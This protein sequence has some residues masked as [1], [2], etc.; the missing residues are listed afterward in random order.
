MPYKLKLRNS[1]NQNIS[2]KILKRKQGSEQEGPEVK[3]LRKHS[4]ADNSELVISGITNITPMKR[5][6]D[7]S[8]QD[9]S[10]SNLDCKLS[11]SPIYYTIKRPRYTDSDRPQDSV[12]TW[13]T[14]LVTSTPRTTPNTKKLFFIDHDKS[15]QN[16]IDDK[17]ILLNSQNQEQHKGQTTKENLGKK[18]DV[19]GDGNCLFWSIFFGYLLPVKNDIKEF[20]TRCSKILPRHNIEEVKQYCNYLKLESLNT[21]NR[22]ETINSNETIGALIQ[23][24]RKRAY[25]EV[26]V[27]PNI[28]GTP[29]KKDKMHNEW[30]QIMQ[31]AQ[32]NNDNV[33]SDEFWGEE[34]GLNALAHLLDI[35]INVE[36][37]GQKYPSQ[38]N[39]YNK[40]TGKQTPLKV[41]SNIT[42]TL[43][44]ENNHYNFYYNDLQH[45]IPFNINNDSGIGDSFNLSAEVDDLTIVEEIK[46]TKGLKHLSICNKDNIAKSIKYAD[47]DRVIPDHNVNDHIKNTS[48]PRKRK[49]LLEQ[50]NIPQKK[51][52]NIQENVIQIN[53]KEND[54]T[55]TK[56]STRHFKKSKQSNQDIDYNKVPVIKYK[57]SADLNNI[58]SQEVNKNSTNSNSNTEEYQKRLTEELNII[59]QFDYAENF[60]IAANIV[61]ICQYFD[62]R[63]QLIGSANSS[64]VAKAL[65]IHTINPIEH[66][67]LFEVFLSDDRQPDFDFYIDSE[68]RH[69]ICNYLITHAYQGR[70]GWMMKKNNSLH[71]SAIGIKP[72]NSNLAIKNGNFTDYNKCTDIKGFIKFDL[73]SS[74]ELYKFNQVCKQQTDVTKRDSLNDAKT[75]QLIANGDVQNL[76]QIS[77]MGKVCKELHPT[78]FNDLV[79]LLAVNRSIPQIRNTNI[80]ILAG[81]QLSSLIDPLSVF[82]STKGVILFKEQIM[83]AANR[84]FGVNVKNTYQFLKDLKDKKIGKDEKKQYIKKANIFTDQA[85]Q[86]FTELQKASSSVFSKAHAISCAKIIYNSAYVKAHYP[87]LFKQVYNPPDNL[88][89]RK[90]PS[91][92]SLITLDD[93][94]DNTLDNS[95]CDQNND[96]AAN[97]SIRKSCISLGVLY[98]LELLMLILNRVSH[99]HDFL[100]ATEEVSTGKFDDITI[101]YQSQNKG[102]YIQAKYIDVE[103]AYN[104]IGSTKLFPK[105]KR[106]HTAMFSIQRYFEFFVKEI[107]NGKLSDAEYLIIYTN[108]NLDTK[109]DILKSFFL[110]HYNIKVD[111]KNIDG[112]EYKILRD[113]LYIKNASNINKKQGFY[114][115]SQESKGKILK[116]LKCPDHDK[117]LKDSFLDKLILAVNQPNVR[118]LIDVIESEMVQNNE[119]SKDSYNILQ[120]NIFSWAA[121]SKGYYITEKNVKEFFKENKLPQ[122][123]DLTEQ[124]SKHYWCNALIATTQYRFTLCTFLL[125]R[126]FIVHPSDELR[127]EIKEN[128]PHR[129]NDIYLHDASKTTYIHI[130]STIEPVSWDEVIASITKYFN[131][132]I[133]T[134]QNNVKDKDIVYYINIKEIEE[135]NLHVIDIENSE[136]QTLKNYLYINNKSEESGFYQLSQEARQEI[137]EQ[138]KNKTDFIKL[139]KIYKQLFNKLVLAVNQPNSIELSSIIKLEMKPYYDLN[140]NYTT[141]QK[142]LLSWLV[143]YDRNHDISN[144]NWENFITEKSN[145]IANQSIHSIDNR[146]KNAFV[147]AIVGDTGICNF[148]DLRDFLKTEEGN[149]MFNVFHQNKIEHHVSSI[150]SN[151]GANVKKIFKEFYNILF[152]KDGQKTNL[153]KYFTEDRT[154]L[155]SI[156]SMLCG[157]GAKAP[158]AL[159]ALH[160]MLSTTIPNGKQTYLQFFV[161]KKI[162]PNI[163]SM[164]CGAG[165]KA[166]EALKALHD[167]LS[168]TIPNGKQTYLQFFVKKK[169]MPNISS[170]LCG[171]GDKAPEALKA[172][173]DMLSTTIPNGK[174]TYL[175]FFV[176][177]KIMPNISSMLCGAGDKAPEALKA[178][179]DMLS[180]TIPN[181]EQTYLQFFVEKKIM[182]N[183]SSMLCGAGAKAPEALK[184]LHDML[185]TTIPNGEQTYLQFFVEKKIMPNISSMLHGAGAKAPEA[186]KALHDMLSTTI[187]NGE[188]TYLQFF[189]EKKIMPN[190]SSMLHGAGDKAPEALKALH[191]MLSTTIPNGEQT[192]LQ[193]FVEKKIMPNISSMLC[194]AGDKAPEALK[195]LHDMLSTTIPNGE[196]TYLQF[197]VEKKI[198]PNISSMLHGAGAKAPE[199]LKALHDMLS[200][201]IPNGEQ[202]YLQFFVEKKIMPN[203]SSMLCGAGAKAPEALKALHDMLSTTIPNGEQTYLQFFVEKKIMPNISSMLCG[204]GDKAPE[205]L[206]ALHD[207]LSTTIPNGEQ[208]YLQFFVEKK[209]MPNISSMLNG[210][211]AKAPE[212]LKALHDMLS[213]TIPNGEQTYLQFFV[214]KKI[215]PNISSMLHGAGAKAPEALK[216]LHDMLSTT[217]P[218]GEQTY[219]QFFVEK[220]IMPNISS[221]LCGAG[222]KAPE[223][224]KALHD[225][226][227][228][229]IPNGEQTYLQ[230]FVEKKIMPNISSMLCG[231]GAKAPEA[232]KALHDM[233][234]TTIPNGEQ[235]YLQFFVE[236]KIMPN[237][238]SMLHGAGAKAPEAL[239]ALHDMLSTTIP[240][241]EQTYLQFFVEKKIM[242]NISSMLCG[243]GA[244]APE[245]LKALH[246]MLST[247][248]PNGEQTYLQFFVEK[249]I[250]PNISSMLCGAGAKAPEALKAL[251]DMLSTTI[252]NGEQTY[253]QFFVEKK[254]MPNISSMLNGAGAK[255]PEALKALITVLSNPI[256]DNGKQTYLQFFVEKKIMPNI[257]SMLHG[258]GAKAPEALKALITVLSNPIKDNGKQTYLQFFVEKKIMPNISSMLNGA[259]AKAPEA[260]KALHDMLSTTIPNGEQTY[261]QFFVEKKIM[262]NISS[263][264]NG[265]GAKAPE[266][267]KKICDILLKSLV[268]DTEI[269]DDDVE[270]LYNDLSNIFNNGKKGAKIL[271]DLKDLI[272]NYKNYE[273]IGGVIYKEGKGMDLESIK[274]NIQLM[275]ELGLQIDPVLDT[276]SIKRVISHY[277]Q[278]LSILL[279][280]GDNNAHAAV[281]LKKDDIISIID[282]LSTKSEFSDSLEEIMKDIIDSG[283]KVNILYSG[284]QQVNSST[285]VDISLIL[286]KNI[287]DGLSDIRLEKDIVKI[288]S[289]VRDMTYNMLSEENQEKISLQD[290]KEEN[291]NFQEHINHENNVAIFSELIA[292]VNYFHDLC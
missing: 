71:Q 156:S 160:D 252:P 197:F 185:S 66:Q 209:I 208:T 158:E 30:A 247:T 142:A 218:N 258:A 268:C 262:P 57:N 83:Q 3:K 159:K 136:Y 51:V 56:T 212:A 62:I 168:T 78:C 38:L 278:Y 41:K 224:L 110:E 84:Y 249:K 164:L 275:R 135:K 150:L 4:L 126:G 244:K 24:L 204:A 8:F 279:I 115:L 117:K 88:V 46:S 37:T 116:L 152:N 54:F 28:H 123:N 133:K 25:E 99:Q 222:A 190:I 257:S 22:N 199:A 48:S 40:D 68:Q 107:N 121:Q 138:L 114:K 128:Q 172:L 47:V 198:M 127:I 166:P 19:P 183:I 139:K 270:Q 113:L 286:I 263:M 118:E 130:K 162:M 148:R 193:F 180:T 254:I 26:K 187:P 97:D 2:P 153:L 125:C 76:F 174:Q 1:A 5:V 52:Y 203:I 288:I 161:K 235:T 72:V 10:T 45:N 13:K 124:Y 59:K 14:D 53:V 231:A 215:I 151:T 44:L 173:H 70:A 21:I 63:Y 112:E 119:L 214:E 95:T 79:N 85:D 94:V 182:P 111:K 264:L 216:A 175:Q 272:K 232:L 49:F 129:L 36:P 43:S 240:N 106:Q 29:T 58:L 245:A 50:E 217:I 80:N 31:N 132:L 189:V 157:A 73:L 101:R 23:E 201:T 137:L 67:L 100:L 248:I 290:K 281:F 12:V 205:A 144:N 228:T 219:L 186:L 273:D 194:G 32:Y 260:L 147:N 282:P 220:K 33:I 276:I 211:G 77:K 234:S 6:Y 74:K 274:Y 93:E 242:P 96:Q 202:T 18:Y 61:K 269:D 122:D 213:T 55:N 60:L 178:L 42:I 253:L 82:S 98:Q 207:M 284:L 200:T 91:T 145:K 256:K 141:L 225:M 87:E 120:D 16:A 221:M 237:I 65:N 15:K 11:D 69:I 265:A 176:K 250:M 233:L 155:C 238:S 75:Y 81:K 103:E 154:V 34:K 39:E 27:R 64:L 195:A 239:K 131:A 184:A 177:K 196:Q 259:G 227:S 277:N 7:T 246:D 267:F 143:S 17:I 146:I 108:A 179:H 181:G 140:I 261:L 86:L 9:F 292:E 241:G 255:A 251:H 210:A 167:M 165:A 104:S 280:K 163:S 89:R 169:I 188:Q 134:A 35:N 236:K 92:D 285:C 289:N 20:A 192:Y 287:A 229:T 271:N 206:K 223:A 171:A 90:L 109:K 226:L 266:A 230:F 291:N 170:M 283:I 243:A 105:G 102:I 191:D 149:T